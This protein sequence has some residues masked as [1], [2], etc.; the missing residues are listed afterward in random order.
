[1]PK[2][3]QYTPNQIESTVVSQPRAN[4]KSLD[5]SPLAKGLDDISNVAGMVS[6]RINTTSA[7]EALVKFERDKNDI[8]FNPDSGYFNTQGRFA[9]DSAVSTNDAVT[10]LKKTYGD[11]LSPAARAKFDKVADQHITRAQSDIAQH[12]SKGLQT[13]EVATIESQVENTLENA[14]LYWNQADKLKIQ[15]VLGEQSI[16]ESSKMTGIGPEA[17]AEKLQTFRSSFAA[18]AI[19]A[20][21][22]KSSADGSKAFDQYGDHLE[23]PQ[24]VK[25]Q[26]AIETKQKSEKIQFDA[27]HATLTATNLVSVYDN[28]SDIIDE[29][30]K[31]KDPVLRKKTMS[32]AMYSYGQKKTAE[33]E[34]R[35]DLFEDAESHVIAGGTA[36]TFQAQNPEAWLKLSPKQQQSISGGKAI[37]TD[38]TIYSDVITM[39]KEQLAKV[40]PDDYF[41]NLAVAE[42][43]TLISAVKSAKG[44]GS[45]SEK[46]SSQVGRTRTTQTNLAVEQLFGKKSKWKKDEIS[47]VN[48]FYSMLDGEVSFRESEKGAKL[49]SEEYTNLLSGLTREVVQDKSSLFWVNTPFDSIAGIPLHKGETTSTIEDIPAEDMSELTNFLRSNNIPVTADN[50][51]KVYKQASK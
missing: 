33:A 18:S 15:R 31:I 21:T 25:M 39:P 13:W 12:S 4:L 9:Y 8:F 2:V 37:S 1:M 40:N 43:K 11:T 49:T 45:S 34:E 19:T 20:A 35:A 51:I 47:K 41:P 46:D 10:K 38:W 48:S 24:K 28:R 7:E 17:T 27:Q 5:L 6:D 26:S 16:L 29:V 32:Q 36:E 22:L 50:L 23:G 14:S 3:A 30:N 44:I 42:R